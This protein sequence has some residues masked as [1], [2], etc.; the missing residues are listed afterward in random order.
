MGGIASSEVV[1]IQSMDKNAGYKAYEQ[2]VTFTISGHLQTSGDELGSQQPLGTMTLRLQSLPSNGLLECFDPP[3]TVQVDRFL[4]LN[5]V[6][7]SKGILIGSIALNY[8][9]TGASDYFNTPTIT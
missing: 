3:S 9:Y 8:T 6:E 4:P 1:V 2:T 7:E 5:V